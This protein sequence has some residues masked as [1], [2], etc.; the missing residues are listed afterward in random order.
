MKTVLEKVRKNKP[1]QQKT[2]KN[3]PVGGSDRE[4]GHT[5]GSWKDRIG[6]F[7]VK[8]TQKKSQQFLKVCTS[9]VPISRVTYAKFQ[10]VKSI[11]F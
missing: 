9:I 4:D 1:C 8:S 7:Y 10:H 3:R 11:R 2:S 6:S 5:A